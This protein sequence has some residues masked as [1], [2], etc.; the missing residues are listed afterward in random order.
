VEKFLK[1]VFKDYSKVI[2]QVAHSKK[3]LSISSKY[4]WL[5]GARYTNLRDI[6]SFNEIGFIDID[7]KNY[8][9]EKH[10]DAVSKVNPMFTVAR[11]VEDIN[12]LDTIL[13]EAERLS[14]FSQY[15]LVVPKDIRMTNQFDKYIPEKY[16]L[17]YSVPTKYGGTKIPVTSFK[18]PVHLL[19]GRPDVQR[20]LADL[21]PVV[22]FD[23]NR[24]T[25]DARFGDYFNGDKFIKHPVGGYE[26]CIIDSIENINRIW[27]N[28]TVKEDYRLDRYTRLSERVFT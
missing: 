11:D 21:M 15:T 7:W 18:R 25:F 5:P 14:E 26:R 19:G 6:K 3:V 2:M 16:L 20:K 12:D 4:N 10:L 9:F 23:C 27:E 1:K 13:K 28:Y 24:F 22:S 8:D 17:A